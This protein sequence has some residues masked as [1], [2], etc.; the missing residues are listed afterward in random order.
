MTTTME[1]THIAA[2][3]LRQFVADND[4]L[5]TPY[6]VMDLDIVADRYDALRAALAGV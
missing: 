5:P 3:R 6:L 2:D 1:H 4:H